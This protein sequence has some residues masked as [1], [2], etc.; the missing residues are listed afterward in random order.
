MSVRAL[1][2]HSCTKGWFRSCETP[3]HMASRLRN[4]GFQGVEVSQPFR[5][6]KMDVRGCEMSLMCQ[7]VSS[8]L[9][10][11]SQMRMGGCKTI[12]QSRDDFRSGSL[13]A[14]KF[15]RP[16]SLL[17]FELLL[18]LNFLL[19]PLLTFLLILIIQ[20]PML[21]QNKLELNH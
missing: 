5:N 10:K 3:F 8:Q 18:I 14:V 9:R 11:F 4:G 13:L 16:C 20:K 19:S 15:R 17:A 12:L 7:G 2:W 1:K 6:C 21:H